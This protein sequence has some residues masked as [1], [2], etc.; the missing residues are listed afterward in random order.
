[1]IRFEELAAAARRGDFSF[2]LEQADALL[3]QGDCPPDRVGWVFYYKCDAALSTDKPVLAIAAGE[4]AL[5]WA[6]AA[7][8][9]DLEGRV[10]IHL[11]CAMLRLGRTGEAAGLLEAYISG[12]KKH[13]E[14]KENEDL[15]RANLAVAYRHSGKLPEAVVQYRKSLELPESRPGSHVQIRQNLAWALLLMGDAEGARSQLD[16]VGQHVR[17][18]LNLDKAMSLWVDRAALHLLE[19]DTAGAKQ[20]CEMVLAALDEK[21]RAVYLATTYVTLGR[22]HLAEGNKE[23]V[24]RCSMLARTHAEKAERWDLHNEATRLWVSASEKGGT[25]SEASGLASAVRLLIVGR[26]SP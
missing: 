4:Q 9:V 6:L 24:Q 16:Q 5:T 10:R 21:N 7:K 15:A 12:M 22:I 2:V 8:D 11:G 3:F 13:P 19:G 18:T 1:M 17:E 20:A 26:G 23:E 14:W 25:A